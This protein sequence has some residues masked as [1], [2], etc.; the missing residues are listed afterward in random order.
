MSRAHIGV[1]AVSLILVHCCCSVVQANPPK[2]NLYNKV[3]AAHDPVVNQ[4]IAAKQLLL[5]ATNDYSGHRSKAGY[6]ISAAVH[7]VLHPGS[8]ASQLMMSKKV[9]QGLSLS[10]PSPIS[11][12]RTVRTTNATAQGASNSNLIKAAQML[13]QVQT[14]IPADKTAVKMHIQ[15]A[16][17]EITIALSIR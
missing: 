9:G 16:L 13:A 2:M 7:E 4:L 15:A 1:V 14:Q 6:E 12:P 3:A 8:T 10:M 11:A 17:D 5:L